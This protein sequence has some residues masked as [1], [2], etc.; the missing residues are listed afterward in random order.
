MPVGLNNLG[1]NSF[2]LNTKKNIHGIQTDPG[3]D[4]NDQQVEHQ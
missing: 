2:L 3:T 1:D 4:K